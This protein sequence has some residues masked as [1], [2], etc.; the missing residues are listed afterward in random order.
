MATVGRTAQIEPRAGGGLVVR[1]VGESTVEPD[2][3]TVDP[4]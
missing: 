1:W 4:M 2:G 3:S